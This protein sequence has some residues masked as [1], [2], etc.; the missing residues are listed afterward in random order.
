MAMN[1]H[2]EE[3]E[4]GLPRLPKG[5]R[6]QMLLTTEEDAVWQTQRKDKTSASDIP[7]K[8]ANV[9]VEEKSAEI[10]CRVPARSILIFISVSDETVTEIH[11]EKGKRDKRNRKKTQ[12]YDDRTIF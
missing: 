9:G 2:W 12:Q 5:L 4:L 8:P 6:W 10:R 1:L 3:H 7:E 11:G